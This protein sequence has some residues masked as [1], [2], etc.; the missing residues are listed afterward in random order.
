LWL[1]FDIDDDEYWLPFRAGAVERQIARCAGWVGARSPLALS[2]LAAYFLVSRLSRP[3]ARARRIRGGVGKGKTPEP[4]SQSGPEEIQRCLAFNQSVDRS[5]APGRGPGAILAWRSSA[6]PAHRRCRGCAWGLEMSGADPQLKDGMTADIE[7]M[8]RIINQFFLDFAE[9]RR[10]RSPAAR[11]S[12]RDCRE[13]RRALTGATGRPVAAGRERRRLP[14]Q[15]RT[16]RR[17]CGASP[18]SVLAKS[19]N[20]LMMR[21][22]SSDVRGHAVLELRI[23]PLIPAR[24]SR[25]SGVRSRARRQRVSSAGPRP[26]ARDRSTLVESARTSVRISSGPD[27]DTGS[28]SCPCRSPPRMRR[29]AQRAAEAGDQ[30]VRR[31]QGQR[32]RE[33]AQP[34]QRSAIWRFDAPARNAQPV[35]VVVESKLS[36]NPGLPSRSL[37]K[38]RGPRRAGA[39]T[40]SRP[41]SALPHR[42]EA[43][44]APRLGRIDLDA[45]ALGRGR[46][47]CS[48]RSSGWELTS[49]E[50]VRLTMLTRFAKIWRARGSTSYARK[51][52]EPA[53]RGRHTRA[54]R[55]RNVRHSSERGHNL[56]FTAAAPSGTNT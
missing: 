34:S 53:D 35:F 2:L 7:E 36:H 13:V 41:G 14:R 43:L 10:R 42:R 12:V 48:R 22:I 55:S 23:G 50:R 31:E 19:R 33:R 8:D 32:Q 1:S 49:A 28:G 5:R 17:A 56:K 4:V 52:L 51:N 3:L 54:A 40:S 6:R 39:A 24:R 20:W 45:F 44:R 38:A 29:R 27:S 47:A 21:S 16:D 25:D 18:P 46:T 37:A 9:D 30:E 26:G 11:R 15:S